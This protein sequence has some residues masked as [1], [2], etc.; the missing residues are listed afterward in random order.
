MSQVAQKALQVESVDF[1]RSHVA[2][3]QQGVARDHAQ[4][5]PDLQP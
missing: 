3:E 2:P 5:W 1:L 4:P